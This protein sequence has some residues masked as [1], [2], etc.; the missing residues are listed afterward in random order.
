MIKRFGTLYAGQVD[1]EDLGFGAT[2]VND[3]FLS[4]EK[5]LEPF[6]TSQKLAVAMDRLGFDT[7]WFAEHHFQREGYE[8]IPNILM[9][10]VHLAHLTQKLRIGCG[11]NVAPM[12][13]PLRLAEDY[14]VA[15]VLTKGR[16]RMGVARGYHTREVESFGAPMLDGDANRELFEEQVDIILKAFNEPSFSH[17]G[18]HYTLPPNV[19]YR[20][21]ELK[22]LTLVPQPVTRPIEMWQPI[23]SQSGRGM[24]FMASRGIKGV[25]GGGAASTLLQGSVIEE[26]QA[27]L[28]RHGRPTQLGG[29]LVI[30]MTYLFA[31]SEQSAY[32]AALP[33]LA[34]YQKM[35]AP[36]GF[37]RPI[38]PEQVELVA[39]PATAAQAGLH[40][41]R[42]QGWVL[43]PP[44]TLLD[45]LLEMEERFPGLE[46]VMVGQPVG[47][48]SHILL[49][50]MEVFGTEVLPRFR[51]KQAKRETTSVG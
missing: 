47:T 21:Y 23:V 17:R 13:H 32:D 20:G 27:A 31:G 10:A 22:E 14:A 30:G 26:W 5:L 1:F 18:K 39:N 24:D 16:V 28:A 4:N 7:L 37:V 46:E 15:D 12:W 41:P 11:F 50:Q 6:E 34:E 25:V 8:C 35:F 9:L 49:E 44:E 51:E 29:D 45:R 48:P 33:L 40:D 19:P 43:G 3:R 2:A 38:T 36:L 42:Q